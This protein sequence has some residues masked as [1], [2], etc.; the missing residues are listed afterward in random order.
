MSQ[1]LK[2]PILDSP[3]P[4]SYGGDTFLSPVASHRAL[5]INSGMKSRPPVFDPFSSTSGNRDSNNMMELNGPESPGPGAY[6][7]NERSIFRQSS[8]YS[9]A[10]PSQ[11]LNQSNS[12]I[13]DR[14][15]ST[16]TISPGPGRY[17]D[18][19][20]QG[21]GPKHN[22]AI[23]I[24]A[25]DPECTFF[26]SPAQYDVAPCDSMENTA[27]G[28]VIPTSPRFD[29]NKGSVPGPGEYKEDDARMFVTQSSS[30][31]SMGGG[32]GG[33]RMVLKAPVSPGPANYDVKVD[34]SSTQPSPPKTAP[35]RSRR[36]QSSANGVPGS[37]DYSPN[38][39]HR[40]A[41]PRYTI[42]KAKLNGII[43]EQK[44]SAIPGPA[45]YENSG[46]T[47]S[48][49]LARRNNPTFGST[50]R[51]NSFE[52]LPPG[53]CAYIPK[54]NF[55]SQ[56]T[57]PSICKNKTMSP[58][59]NGPT[60]QT[61]ALYASRGVIARP[62]TTPGPGAY[63][64]T[65]IGYRR[66][67]ASTMPKSKRDPP[68]GLRTPGPTEYDT[69]PK[70]RGPK[71]SMPQGPKEADRKKKEDVWHSIY[72]PERTHMGASAS[73][74]STLRSKLSLKR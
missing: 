12:T 11:G 62:E 34:F 44:S 51:F 26:P 61:S 43:D 19:E 53:P 66:A 54:D 7:P 56:K 63:I 60:S 13:P 18:A 68:Q 36:F 23:R 20:F 50:Q 6:S 73:L 16:S 48:S 72:F 69:R 27:R 31:Y 1:T 38:S 47:I 42:S 46:E 3:G 45:D 35:P 52:T 58:K 40:M 4:G 28:G 74:G 8:K 17:V 49:K 25:K 37:S 32:P 14:F 24:P 33:Q 55:S 5:T 70:N 10:S 15:A 39:S 41:S 59:T 2:R 57:T 67:P 29:K 64:P 30:K 22:I 71:F 9:F 65:S 21:K